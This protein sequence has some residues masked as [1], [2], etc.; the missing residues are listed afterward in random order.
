MSDQRV[1]QDSVPQGSFTDHHRLAA[2]TVR[3]DLKLAPAWVHGGVVGSR[4]SHR[5]GLSLQLQNHIAECGRREEEGG[6]GERGGRRGKE[7]PNGGWGGM[8]A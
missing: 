4:S 1:Y 7:D 6:R 3:E 2:P 8:A 5:H